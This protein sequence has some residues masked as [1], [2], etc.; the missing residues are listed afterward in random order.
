MLKEPSNSMRATVCL[1]SL[2]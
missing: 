2:Q 1:D